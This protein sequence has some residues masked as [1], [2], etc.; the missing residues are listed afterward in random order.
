MNNYRERR[1]FTLVELNLAIVFVALLMLAVA[2]TTMSVS[3]TYQYG[4]SLKTIN[5]LGR[6]VVDQVRRDA[7]AASPS[8]IVSV[9]ATT[10]GGVGRLCLGNVSYVYNSA[11]LLN[12]SGTMIKDLAT[13]KTITLARIEDRG[14]VWCKMDS[15]G[16]FIKTNISGD[17]YTEMLLTDNTPVAIHS[18]DSETLLNT[19]SN[20][21]SQGVIQVNIVLGTRETQTTSGGVCK[22]PTDPSENFNNCAVRQFIV[23]AQVT[24]E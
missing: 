13:S 8:Q 12:G 15:S 9:D 11:D 4:I 14:G 24:G 2:M 22:P 23:V 5:Q 7:S 19:K 3:H 10:S 18:M 6:E 16:A 17:T 21:F 1:G 20:G